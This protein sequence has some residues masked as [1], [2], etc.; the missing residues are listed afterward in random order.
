VSRCRFS[1]SAVF[2]RISL[3]GIVLQ[4]ASCTTTKNDK[5]IADDLVRKGVVKATRLVIEGK[6]GT[7]H[8]AKNDAEQ[9][10]PRRC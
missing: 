7:I 10:A 2:R 5:S 9:A 3:A 6:G 8:L 1:R 4:F